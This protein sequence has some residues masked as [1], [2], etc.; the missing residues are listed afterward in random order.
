MRPH[1]ED[2]RR[3][4]DQRLI[5]RVGFSP[6]TNLAHLSGTAAII[7]ALITFG[8]KL[9]SQQNGLI[10]ATDDNTTSVIEIRRRVSESERHLSSLDARTKYN[11]RQIERVEARAQSDRKLII[12]RLERVDKKLDRLIEAGP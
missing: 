6:W 7:I 1:E 8:G 2:R 4:E 3:E 12:E 11:Q 5:A 10:K 9:Y